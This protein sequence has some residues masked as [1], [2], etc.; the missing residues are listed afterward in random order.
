MESTEIKILIIDDNNDNLINL[1]QLIERAF[2][3]AATFTA[4]DGKR[5]FELAEAE[6]PDVILL[7][8]V[9]QGINGFEVCQELKARKNLSHIPIVLVSALKGD[10]ENRIKALEAGAEAFITKPIDISELIAQIK[11]NGK[12]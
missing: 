9:M 6:I 12:N 8:I 3:L 4:D 5:G 10:K 11:S 2:P 7:D 1:K